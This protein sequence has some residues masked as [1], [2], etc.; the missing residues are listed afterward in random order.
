MFSGSFASS[1]HTCYKY[2]LSCPN[3]RI[4][5]T[6]LDYGEI[7]LCDPPW[8]TEKNTWNQSVR[9][10]CPFFLPVVYSHACITG[11]VVKPTA[12]WAVTIYM[13]SPDN[14]KRF[15]L[16]CC[17]QKD[18]DISRERCLLSWT[19][20]IGRVSYTLKLSLGLLRTWRK[21]RRVTKTFKCLIL[22]WFELGEMDPDLQ[23]DEIKL[24]KCKK[25]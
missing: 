7:G 8:K 21:L 9:C 14:V 6:I 15:G 13:T 23:L 4:T 1:F 19:F 25:E 24:A 16:L 3:S 11:S 5:Q 18:R 2:P 17:Q 10:S 22:R 20:N 12:Q